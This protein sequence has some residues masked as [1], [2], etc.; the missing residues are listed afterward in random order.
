MRPQPDAIDAEPIPLEPNRPRRGLGTWA[1]LLGALTVREYRARYRQ[2]LLDLGWSLVI[3]LSFLLVYGVIFT[4]LFKVDGEGVP[5]LAF[6]WA[7]LVVWSVF[8]AGLSLGSTAILANADL[9][10]KIYFPREILPLAMVGTALIDLSISLVVLAG[11]VAVQIRSVSITA[12]GLVPA[13]LVIMVWTAALAVLTAAITV[14][15]RDV[16]QVVQL[17][18]RL[19][20]FATPVAYG[21]AVV[22]ASMHFLLWANPIAV[23]IA[24]VRDSVL[25]QVWPGWTLLGIHGLV[26]V[27]LLG[28]AIAYTR[29]VELRMI[30]VI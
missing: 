13:V 29:S 9:I 14:F 27:V 11:V 22:P 23:C 20:I 8:S 17:F 3:P 2:S 1:P 16:A 30:D 18:L 26:G 4:L 25:Y 15:I 28:A 19:V 6:A 24:A 5:Y 7:G 10:S 21:P 12:V